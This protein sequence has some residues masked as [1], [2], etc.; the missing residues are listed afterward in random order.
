MSTI[1]SGSSGL[2]WTSDN[3]SNLAITL[4]SIVDNTGNTVSGSTVVNGS[5]KAWVNFNGTGTVAIRSSFNVSSITDN[6][7][8]RYTVNFTT[9]IPNANYGASVTVS[10]MPLISDANMVST[11]C[12]NT[13]R[14]NPTT[15]SFTV[16]TF[17]AQ[18]NP[19]DIEFVRVAIFS[20]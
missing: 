19:I 11:D 15:T 12:T 14:T 17:N 8:G 1:S 7:T 10:S 13:S 3:S 2:T 6:G 18:F 5:A 20:S 4:T 16:T 9:A